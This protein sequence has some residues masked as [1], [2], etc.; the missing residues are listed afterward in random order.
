MS[1]SSPP[2]RL[3]GLAGLGLVLATAGPVWADPTGSPPPT[4]GAGPPSRDAAPLF[5]SPFGEP[6]RS[7]TG[8]AD[9]FAGA[10]ADHDGTLTLKEFTADGLRFHA[11]LDADRDGRVDGFENTTYENEVAPEILPQSA[12]FRSDREDPGAPAPRS[13]GLDGASS[14]GLLDEPQPVRGADQNYDGKITAEEQ[15]KAA[16]RRFGLLDEGGGGGLTLPPLQAR[17]GARQAPPSGFGRFFRRR[18]D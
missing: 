7:A 6:F 10:D 5:I 18:P 12:A 4:P 8:L 2:R 17:L 1:R 14:F 15:A 11:R 3:A 16:A 9:W 13:R